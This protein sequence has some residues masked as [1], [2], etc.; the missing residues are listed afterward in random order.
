MVDRIVEKVTIVKDMVTPV[1]IGIDQ[2]K[3]SLQEAIGETEA[4]AMI[5]PDQG[6]SYYK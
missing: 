3:E 5:G 6:Q 4:L 2:G 1:E